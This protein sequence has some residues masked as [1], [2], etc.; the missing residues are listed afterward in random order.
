MTEGHYETKGKAAHVLELDF[1]KSDILF[2]VH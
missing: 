2:Q 1:N